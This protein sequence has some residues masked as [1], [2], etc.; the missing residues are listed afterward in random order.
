MY[1][2]PF[3]GEQR[4]WGLNSLGSREEENVDHTSQF[5]ELEIEEVVKENDGNK[6]S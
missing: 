3:G 1:Q 4:L 2:L 6:S 5:M